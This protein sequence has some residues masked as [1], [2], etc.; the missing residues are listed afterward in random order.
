MQEY[1]EKCFSKS[2]EGILAL[3][4]I[5]IYLPHSSLKKK[6]PRKKT[7]Y[8]ASKIKKAYY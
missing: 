6:K 1:P 7:Y 3:L 4:D 8:K 2:F 5:K